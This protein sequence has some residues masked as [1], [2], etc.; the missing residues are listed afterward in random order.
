MKPSASLKSIPLAS[1]LI[2]ALVGCS[3]STPPPVM[4]A[5]TNCTLP[6]T[7]AVTSIYVVQ[8]VAPGATGQPMILQFPANASGSV[9]P[10]SS[11]TLPAGLT[12]GVITESNGNIY[13]ATSADVREYAPG[14]NGAATPVRLIPANATTTIGAV[15]G[16]AVDVSGNI[17]VSEQGGGIAIFDAMANGSV[18]PSRYILGNSQPG[19]GL[20][21]IENPG[22]LTTDASGNLY[23]ANQDA[24]RAGSILVFGPTA[25]GNVAPTSIIAG[26]STTLNGAPHGIATD[27]LG[28]LYIANNN[29]TTPSNSILVFNAGANGNVA[30][31]RTIIGSS[32]QLGVL[33]GLSVDPLNSTI[34][35]VTE[36]NPFNNV[37]PGNATILSFAT[38][39]S[40][41]VAPSSSFMSPQWTVDANVLSLA[42]H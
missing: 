5:N 19:G 32:T 6:I 34:F 36:G 18:G 20:S 14:S 29:N 12:L 8:N 3:N 37:L 26:A 10:E 7:P 27:P 16:L 15:T 4:C 21:T 11:I 24:H 1:T 13:V 38:S 25:T 9:S 40:G 35:V 41:N 33:Y 42:A 22:A 39:A 31:A 2:L 30:P 17:F 23:V 28:N